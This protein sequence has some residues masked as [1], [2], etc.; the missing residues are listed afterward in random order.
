MISAQPRAKAKP[1]ADPYVL[2]GVILLPDE[3]TRARQAEYL[4]SR[5][6][7]NKEAGE[8]HPAPRGRFVITG[9]PAGKVHIRARAPGYAEGSREVT[10]PRDESLGQF[11]IV[12]GGERPVAKIRVFESRHGKLCNKPFSF[13]LSWEREPGTMVEAE[14]TLTTDAT[15][16]I[17]L[18]FPPQAPRLLVCPLAR[19]PSFSID[20]EDLSRGEIIE[21][22]PIGG[23]S[24]T[25]TVVSPEGEPVP[26]AEVGLRIGDDTRWGNTVREGV[27]TFW[28]AQPGDLRLAARDRHY[29]PSRETKIE[30]DGRAHLTVPALKLKPAASVTVRVRT[31]DD[32]PCKGARVSASGECG[33]LWDKESRREYASAEE[34]G[35]AGT[36]VLDT[37]QPGTWTIRA[38]AEHHVRSDKK[39]LVESGRQ[40]EVALVLKPYVNVVLKVSDPSGKPVTN[41]ELGVSVAYT[42]VQ[43]RHYR[44]P[45]ELAT[46][47]RG[48]ARLP[49]VPPGEVTLAVGCAK[50][51]ATKEGVVLT[52]GREASV[53]I[54]LDP[55]ASVQGVIVSENLQLPSRGLAIALTRRSQPPMLQ[56]LE[57]GWDELANRKPRP[58]GDMRLVFEPKDTTKFRFDGIVPPNATWWVHLV[59]LDAVALPVEIG[60]R[61]GRIT[62]AK[63]VARRPASVSGRV[64]DDQG[65][66]VP[67]AT[68]H[69]RPI[70]L[71]DRPFFARRVAS[72]REDG[73]FEADGLYPG[74]W[75]LTA[76]EYHHRSQTR[77]TVL[78][79]GPVN[80]PVNFRLEAKADSSKSDPSKD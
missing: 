68:I 35:P 41:A 36:Y 40:C 13:K 57:E 43:R 22:R 58:V 27:Y 73:R 61:S 19:Y 46:D 49:H 62:R 1:K 6:E 7:T 51:Y 79:A 59:A 16:L 2:P 54:E 39:R 24:V 52:P 25:G 75:S 32:V 48:I 9:L 47:R 38:E 29:A 4:V 74:A 17:L 18:E 34:R 5:S 60:L 10:V 56:P 11:S 26:G 12:L 77:Q 76:S 8:W 37:L 15:G 70:E 14:R 64:A 20:R 55:P 44:Q 28:E 71:R 23:Y 3:K 31:P 21:L 53:S 66:P 45:P 33:T 50:G 78:V 67:W 72:T 63:L 30:Y 42:K 65:K 80:V 69:G